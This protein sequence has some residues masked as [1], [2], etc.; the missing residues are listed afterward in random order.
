MRVF[1]LFFLC[2]HL[3]ATVG[4]AASEEVK[5]LELSDKIHCPDQYDTYCKV[6][7]TTFQ[8]AE[9]VKTV[10]LVNTTNSDRIV[11]IYPLCMYGGFK[12]RLNQCDTWRPNRTHAGR[13][14]PICEVNEMTNDKSCEVV[15][16]N[17]IAIEGLVTLK[18]GQSTELYLTAYIIANQQHCSVYIKSNGIENYRVNMSMVNMGKF[19]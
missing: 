7:L 16:P 2:I 17:Q 3:V 8:S 13:T 18:A 14:Q 1:S 5:E 11:E 12:V 9:E 15:F 19:N 6:A 10:S 4:F